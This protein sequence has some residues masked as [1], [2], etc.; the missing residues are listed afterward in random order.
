MEYILS[1]AS[2]SNV[3][4]CGGGRSLAPEASRRRIR[5]ASKLFI[6]CTLTALLSACKPEIRIQPLSLTLPAPVFRLAMDGYDQAH[7]IAA[8]VIGS[9]GAVLWSIEVKVPG[10]LSGATELALIRQKTAA[11][12]SR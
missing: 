5:P 3:L 11:G 8:R 12:R 10:V 4:S 9:D 2:P 1:I 6:V 7:F